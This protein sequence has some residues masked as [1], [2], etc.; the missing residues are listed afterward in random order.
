MIE[1]FVADYGVEILFAVGIIL[2]A[3]SFLG[4][5]K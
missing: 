3:L 4:R 1:Q 2:I 5:Q